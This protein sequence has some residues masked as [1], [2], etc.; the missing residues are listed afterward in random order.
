VSPKT[1]SWN[2]NGGLHNTF[3]TP[4]ELETQNLAQMCIIK[5]SLGK[6]ITFWKR[7]HLGFK[8]APQNHFPHR[9]K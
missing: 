1:Q 9:S 6:Y 2:Q 3:S 8:M 5:S 7:R 4:F